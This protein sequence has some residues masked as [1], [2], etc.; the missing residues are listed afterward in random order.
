MTELSARHQYTAARKL[1]S[2]LQW[3]HPST[4]LR[5][6]IR[7][8]R[9][10]ETRKLPGDL[11]SAPVIE[12]QR[13]FR[14]RHAPMVTLLIIANLL[15]FAVE[16]YF[17][18]TG[19]GESK[20]LLR[21]GAVDPVHVLIGHEY[22]RLFAALFLHAGEVH[23]AFYLFA[24]YVLGPPFERAIGSLRFIACYLIAG[25]CSTAG[26]L[27]LWR[28][29]LDKNAEPITLQTD[30]VPQLVGASGCVMGIV[31]AWAALLIRD[32]HIPSVRRRLM[33]IVTIIVIQTLFD[34]TTPEV[35]MTAHLFGLAGGFVV[36][37]GVT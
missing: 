20:M 7:T 19:L 26:V 21:L 35:S 10:L 4:D 17:T 29:G 32:H 34:L 25:L 12:K 1:A 5:D 36:G 11:P 28:L 9:Y 31:G 8:L 14:L 23:L 22:W 16:R 13:P 2:A 27:I 6:Q 30:A 37:L 18:L 33:N 3:L 24:L 15:A